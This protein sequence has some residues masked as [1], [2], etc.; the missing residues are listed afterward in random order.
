[1]GSSAA[2]GEFGKIFGMAFPLVSMPS[3]IIGSLAVVLVPELSSNY[4]SAKYTT[5]KNNVEKAIK[6]SVFAACLIIPIFLSLGREIG[7]FLYN[8]EIAGSY[9][10]KA[11]AMTL[12][13]SITIISTSMLNSLNKEKTTLL[14]YLSGASLMLL[15]IYFLPKYLGVNSLIVGMAISYVVSSVA[16]VILLYKVSPVKPKIL[17]YIS[18]SCLFIIPS[19]LLGLLAKN[20]LFARLPHAVALIVCVV[21]VG[22]FQLGLFYVF[23]MTDFKAEN[24]KYGRSPFTEKRSGK[25]TKIKA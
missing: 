19:T 9:V 22:L 10:V 6:F 11:A 25:N 21:A 17:A 5:L 12:P 23:G 2:I 20:L 24:H 8:D 7:V 18:V 1:M 15:C 14:F 4:Y 16:N 3:T 13:L